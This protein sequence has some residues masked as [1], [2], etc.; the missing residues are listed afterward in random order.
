MRTAVDNT[1]AQGWDN[2]GSVSLATAVHPIIR[3]LT[4]LT[5]IHNIYSSVRW[6]AGANN[7]M[8]DA[9]SRLTH[10]TDMMFLQH[11]SLTFLQK[12][13]WRLITLPLGYRRRLTS[14]L[15]RKRCCID[16]QSP[17]SKNTPLPVANGA[18]SSN[19]W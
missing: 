3:E 12:N 7:T 11:F 2:R 9:A 19:G 15:H 4:L 8:T 13:R 1:E 18:S 16:F 5:R 6:I 10:I 14:M 17:S